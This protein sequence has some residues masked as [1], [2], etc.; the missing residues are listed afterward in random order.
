M[1]TYYKV[2][3]PKM[4]GTKTEVNLLKS[5]KAKS[6]EK[7]KKFLYQQAAGREAPSYRQL[8]NFMGEYVTNSYL[9]AAIFHRVLWGPYTDVEMNLE[10][11]IRQEHDHAEH[12]FPE[13][14]KIAREEGFEE[15]AMAFEQMAVVDSSQEA[16]L[17]DI[18]NK[19]RSDSI[20]NKEGDQDWYCQQCGH[21]H[22]GAAAPESCSLCKSPKRFFELKGANFSTF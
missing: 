18:L 10:A 7:M 1:G 11:L 19:L 8:S 3:D 5:W 4:N 21:I 12:S 14:A 15:I 16:K 9:H 13:Y 17:A 22:H 20:F 2:K 6:V